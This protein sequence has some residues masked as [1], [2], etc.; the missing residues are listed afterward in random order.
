LTRKLV[1]AS[2]GIDL[3]GGEQWARTAA[4]AEIT[5]VQTRAQTKGHRMSALR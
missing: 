2:D 5:M 3:R 4:Y 1:D